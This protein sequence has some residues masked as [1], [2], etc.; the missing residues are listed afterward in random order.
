MRL[1]RVFPLFIILPLLLLQVYTARADGVLIVRLEGPIN[2]ATEEFVNYALSEA[3][4]EQASLLVFEINT[5]GGLL[6]SMQ[7]I[8]SQLLAAEVP[9]VAYVTPA[10]ASATSAGVFIA[11]A[12]HLAVMSPGTTIGAAHP[13]MGDGSNIDGDMRAKMENSLVSLG[14]A[15][16]EQRARNAAWIEQAVRESVSVTDREAQLNGVINF[17]AADM[18]SLLSQ[19]EGQSVKVKSQSVTLGNL[20]AQ[21]RKELGWTLRQKFINFLADPNIAVFLSFGAIIG[22]V[23]EFLVPGVILPGL[24]GVLCLILALVAG[25]VLPINGAGLALLI[26]GLVLMVAEMFLPSFG[27]VGIIGVI[28]LLIGGFYLVDLEQVW[29]Q[30]AYGVSLY[31]LAAV[32]IFSS[33]ILSVISALGLKALTAPEASGKESFVGKEVIVIAGAQEKKTGVWQG[34][35]RFMGEV[36]KAE[37]VPSAEGRIPESGEKL[38]IKEYREGLLL[39]LEFIPC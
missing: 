18:D 15:I 7:G 22:L 11:L 26:F 1:S 23:I 25:S 30:G 9:T 36:W 17:T 21:P 35:V 10:G 27:V 6:K 34:K 5:P 31:L 32:G 8:V 14:Q 37:L 19:L 39:L 4:V 24:F 12:A 2:P 16:A 3:K 28:S 13:V 33:L 20:K 29:T 38:K